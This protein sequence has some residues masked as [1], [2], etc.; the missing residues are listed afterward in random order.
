MELVHG[1]LIVAACVAI[2]D[3]PAKPRPY[4]FGID[5]G[6]IDYGR[7]AVFHKRRSRPLV[8]NLQLQGRKSLE[9]YAP[10][11]IRLS[12]SPV[13]QALKSPPITNGRRDDLALA[14]MATRD[15]KCLSSFSL[16]LLLGGR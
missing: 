2:T 9:E 15:P 7:L 12:A 14:T 3:F 10:A 8:C 1:G 6:E 4:H 13:A 11:W 16:S 5:E